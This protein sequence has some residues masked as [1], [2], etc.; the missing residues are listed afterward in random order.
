V[1][2]DGKRITGISDSLADGRKTVAAAGTAEQFT[3][4]E[5]R[6]VAITALSSNTNPVVIGASTVVAAVAT[7]RGTPLTAG[8][9]L[10]IAVSNMNLLYID[11]VT[12]GEGVSFLVLA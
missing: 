1:Y 4:L 9:T 3:A 5:C 10:T 12:S 2:R 6:S 8:Q 11:A 7:R